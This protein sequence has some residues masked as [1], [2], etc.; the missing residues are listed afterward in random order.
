[1]ASVAS[2]LADNP[3]SFGESLGV[4]FSRFLESKGIRWIESGEFVERGKFKEKEIS[5]GKFVE[6]VQR[7]LVETNAYFAEMP[8]P[9]ESFEDSQYNRIYRELESEYSTEFA[10]K[11]ATKASHPELYRELF[12]EYVREFPLPI[13]FGTGEIVLEAFQKY[14]PG[15]CMLARFG[16]GSEEWLQI[17]S[18]NPDSVGIV[19]CRGKHPLLTS[20][21][22]ALVWFG[23]SETMVDRLY[24]SSWMLSGM[25]EIYSD[26]VRKLLES[27][28]GKP[29][30]TIS[31]HSANWRLPNRTG[32]EPVRFRLK[33]HGE[34]MPYCDTLAYSSEP[35]SDGEIV[36]SSAYSSKCSIE[37][38]DTEGTDLKNP[39][40]CKCCNCSESLSEDDC[41]YVDGSGDGPYCCD[42]YSENYSY[43]DYDSCDCPA[44][45]VT[46]ATILD[47]QGNERETSIS[48]DT[49]NS[50]F[51]EYS[52][53]YY[54]SV[55]YIHNR[56]AIETDSGEYIS[57]EDCYG[58]DTEPDELDDDTYIVAYDDSIAYRKSELFWDEPSGRWLTVP[59]PI[60]YEFDNSNGEYER[61]ICDSIAI[62]WNP[63]SSHR[64]VAYLRHNGTRTRI[65]LDNLGE[66]DCLRYASIV[67]SRFSEE[68]REFIVNWDGNHTTDSRIMAD[69]IKD[70]INSV[71]YEFIPVGI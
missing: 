20:S 13:E 69:T 19:F 44:D 2:V 33:F 11:I 52:G 49:L 40:K 59:V 48:Q 60:A 5:A 57:S 65:Q 10:N 54:D 14:R 29:V 21:S 45:S 58:F 46:M 39:N 41:Y 18:E 50:D 67:N 34:M 9:G 1:M 32:T 66:F 47:R 63:S 15:S 8:E 68:I 37:C 22:S 55:E 31:K 43:S 12:G 38:R 61:K 35:D 4:T 51:Y 6:S 7:F 70:I 36:L 24:S 25:S 56:I 28:L 23:K 3:G 71:K 62:R 42:C 64:F 26:S 16:S 27:E 53:E 30:V 17:Y